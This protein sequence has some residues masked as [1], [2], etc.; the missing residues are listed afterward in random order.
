MVIRGRIDGLWLAFIGWFLENAASQSYQQ[1]ALREALRGVKAGDIMNRECAYV[2]GDLPVDQFVHDYIL[3]Q[4]RRCFLLSDSGR[5]TGIVTMH[6][7]KGVPRTKWGNTSVGDIMTPLDGVKRVKI[8]D[9]ALSVLELMDRED[10]N[11]VPVMDGPRLAGL[12]SRDN[13]LRFI[14]ARS[15]L[16]I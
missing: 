11:Q 15:E 4:S 5:L 6:N 12:V 10:I 1:V 9:D 7:V 14:R 13:V 2:P 3:P 8:T 16:G